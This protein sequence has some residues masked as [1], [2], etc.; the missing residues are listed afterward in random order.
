MSEINKGHENYHCFHKTLSYMEKHK[1]PLSKH[2]GTNK[3]VWKSC[4]IQ[5]QHIKIIAIKYVKSTFYEKET[6]KAIY[7]KPQNWIL[8]HW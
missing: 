5:N 6:K 2:T 3:W 1:E 7:N 4:R 8:K